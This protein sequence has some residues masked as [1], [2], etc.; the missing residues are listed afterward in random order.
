MV[1]RDDDGDCHGHGHGHSHGHGDGDGDVSWFAVM[2][3]VMVVVVVT[4]EMIQGGPKMHQDSWAYSGQPHLL[5][6]GNYSLCIP[7]FIT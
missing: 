2:V 4:D 3:M 6:E 5:S 7:T 1:I